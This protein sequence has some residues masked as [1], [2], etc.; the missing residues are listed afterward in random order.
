MKRLIKLWIILS[1]FIQLSCKAQHQVKKIDVNKYKG[2]EKS[3]Y[4]KCED[5]DTIIEVVV[6]GKKYIEKRLNSKTNI[7][8]VR[9]YDTHTFLLVEESQ[10]FSEVEIG[11]TKKYN[12]KGVVYDVVDNDI[13][14]SFSLAQVIAV[15]K[16]DF[17]I[18]LMVPKKKRSI[19]RYY[20]N[21]LKKYIYFINEPIDESKERHILL[22]GAT[23]AL[24]YNTL[25]QRGD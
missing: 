25:I 24:M 2:I 13:L 7:T 9:K 5:N 8:V 1:C 20:D 23:G 16:Q 21:A 12:A 10:K 3:G 19:T 11:K 6:I 17:G 4:Y 18:D 15:V 22:N 14:Y